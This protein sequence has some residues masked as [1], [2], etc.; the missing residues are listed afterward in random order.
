M[1][2]W[3]FELTPITLDSDSQANGTIRFSFELSNVKNVRKVSD[4]WQAG[5]T[6]LDVLKG[7]NVNVMSLI[8]L[9]SQVYYSFVKRAL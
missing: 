1:K 3:N 2:F 8:T 6:M 9:V 5:K 4:L 7:S